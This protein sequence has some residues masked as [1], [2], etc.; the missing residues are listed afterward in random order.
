MG[1]SGSAGTS[2][3]PVASKG[4]PA[5]SPAFRPTSSGVLAVTGSSSPAC[6]GGAFSPSPAWRSCCPLLP[7]RRPSP[8]SCLSPPPPAQTL[9]VGVRRK[10]WPATGL[11]ALLQDRA[12]QRR[13][14]SSRVS[15]AEGAAASP[16]NHRAPAHPLPE[17]CSSLRSPSRVAEASLPAV[18][19][20]GFESPGAP[21]SLPPSPNRLRADF[22]PGGA[23]D[24][25][26]RL[27]GAL[28]A[29]QDPPPRGDG[30]GSCAPG[31]KLRLLAA[32]ERRGTPAEGGCAQAPARPA[33]RLS[34]VRAWA[35]ATGS[36]PPPA[37]GLARARPG[38]AEPP[39]RKPDLSGPDPLSEGGA[40]A[41]GL[42]PPA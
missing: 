41:L 19:R 21:P 9:P 1:L 11:S 10:L 8:P 5:R 20:C 4:V 26:W 33:R 15:P 32:A 40:P 29:A 2:P 3:L 14:P 22:P 6:R 7:A 38:A 39:A 12:G 24:G 16:G 13:A 35:Q 42:G 34:A 23:S 31:Q 17:V 37:F 25:P 30:L 18:R 27:A 36:R 28:P